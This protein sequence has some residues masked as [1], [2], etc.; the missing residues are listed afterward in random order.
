MLCYK[1]VGFYIVDSF[2]CISLTK[3]F[4]Y[5]VLY[6]YAYIYYIRIYIVIEYIQ[7]FPIFHLHILYD[8]ISIITINSKYKILLQIKDT[9]SLNFK[10]ILFVF[11]FFQQQ[12]QQKCSLWVFFSVKFFLLVVYIG[13]NCHLWKALLYYV[14]YLSDVLKTGFP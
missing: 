9:I 3:V 6:T 13:L 5:F 12:Q 2:S 8:I 1:T 7:H 14:C 10:L 4:L 11:K